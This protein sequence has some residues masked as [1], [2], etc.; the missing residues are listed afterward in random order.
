MMYPRLK[1]KHP[2]L[3]VHEITKFA[4][5]EWNQLS[6]A[7]K[8]EYRKIC[9]DKM[10][11]Y[12]ADDV[13]QEIERMRKEIEEILHDRPVKYRYSS[14]VYFIDAMKNNKVSV[15]VSLK[16]ASK[17]FKAMNEKERSILEKKFEETQQDFEKW[18]QKVKKD[19]RAKIMKDLESNL[20]ERLKSLQFDKPKRFTPPHACYLQQN[21]KSF[22]GSTNQNK[23]Q[24]CNK[25]WKNLSAAEKEPYYESLNK[26]NKDMIVWKET[27]SQDGRMEVIQAIKKLLYKLKL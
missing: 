27:T 23:L 3:G 17:E 20:S 19:G 7:E 12:E 14:H 24:E 13:K 15:D 22:K 18:K 6:E 26:Y 5:E 1:D 16:K 25:Q 11:E 21:C 4:A 8:E 9:K 2:N 10:I